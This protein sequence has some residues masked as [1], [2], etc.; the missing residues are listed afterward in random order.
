MRTRLRR[1]HGQLE[2][3]LYYDYVFSYEHLYEAACKCRR[4][5]DWKQSVLNYD[6]HRSVS[7]WLLKDEIDFGEYKKK[8]QGQFILHERGKARLISPVY[9]KDRIIQR[10]LCDYS[11]VPILSSSLIYDNSAS[12]EG[13]GTSFTRGRLR[14]HLINAYKKYEDPYILV[15]DYHDFFG[16]I[17]SHR[18]FQMISK[19]YHELCQAEKEHESVRRLL[20]I[21]EI[22]IEDMSCL[23][24]GNQTS[25]TAA[26][27]YPN[28]IDHNMQTYGKYGR[29]MDDGYCICRDY[30]TAIA[31]L[32]SLKTESS[33]L[34]L[35]LNESKTRI[36]R[37]HDNN[38]F[39]F[40]KRSYSFDSNGELI[41]RM[42]KKALRLHRKH[43][44][45]V[46]RRY[47]GTEIFGLRC[48][49]DMKS[50]FDTIT[51]GLTNADGLRRK[52]YGWLE[53]EIYDK[54]AVQFYMSL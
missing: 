22:F 52:Y 44:K 8:P 38:G 34:G 42:N 37:L 25:Q 21:I 27:W 10:A 32:D 9:Y 48:L 13:K 31:A 20:A 28:A 18:C 39:S 30:D 54:T 11:L 7:T 29:Y 23:G 51:D 26:I 2:K 45:N 14:R 33:K 40:L 19:R 53:S 24:L 35:I 49:Q 46:I 4:N 6:N 15:F 50:S 3:S 41:I 17:D 43:D 47:D 16:S 36:V 1:A 5:V 12:L